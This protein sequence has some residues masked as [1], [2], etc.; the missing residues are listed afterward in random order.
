MNDKNLDYEQLIEL[1]GKIGDILATP[2]DLTP[3]QQQERLRALNLPSQADLEDLQRTYE[4]RWEEA[5]ADLES[6]L[7]ALRNKTQAIL[8]DIE[9]DEEEEPP[10]PSPAYG[11]ETA[12]DTEQIENDPEHR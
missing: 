3:Q 1:S 5:Q 2:E 6:R 8:E 9:D 11:T 12:A 10:P 4:Q 7:S